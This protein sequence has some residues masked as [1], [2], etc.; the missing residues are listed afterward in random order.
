MTYPALSA[1]R[2]KWGRHMLV[3]ALFAGILVGSYIAFTVW[4]R[5]GSLDS[6]QQDHAEWAYSQ[7]EIE[8]LKLDRA[9]EQARSG[10]SAELE[11]LRKRF[12]IFYSRI[13]IVD[14]LQEAGDFIPEVSKLRSVVDTQIPL[15]D[16]DDTT[17]FNG[18]DGLQRAL[19][20]IKGSPREIALA[21]IAI[22]A[23]SAQ[24]ERHQIVHLMENLFVI[25]LL[26][27]AAL[28]GA[29]IRLS[30][31][32]ITLNRAT[33]EAE[34]NHLRLETTLR[35]S[36][37]AVVVID[38]RGA[39]RDFN[40]SAETIFAIPRDAALGQDFITLLLP[41]HLREKY[42]GML[43]K[44]RSTGI[45]QVADAG[46]QELEMVDHNGRIF[47]VELS[48]SLA[49]SEEGPIFVTYIRDITDK[50]QKEQ[51]I[52]QARDAALAAYGEKSRFFAMM[53]H[54]MRTPLNGVLSAI[55]LL[56]DGRLDAEQQQYLGAALTSGD[57]L[58]SHINDVLAIERSE[59][60]MD[61]QQ[62][63]PC[64]VAS[65]TSGL[66][67]TME[68]L[69][70]SA[71][72]RLQLDQGGLHDRPILTDPR[73]IQQ[74]LV[75]LLSNAIKFSPDGEVTLRTYYQQSKGKTA[76]LHLEVID[77]GPGIFEEDID[78]IFED[79]VSLDSRYE[80]RTGGTGLGLGIVRRVVQ[81]LSGEIR[82]ESVPGEGARFTV[83]LPV[84]LATPSNMP[85]RTSTRTAY[86]N[87]TP[88]RLLVVDDNEINRDL[89]K[90]M[91][92]RLGH[93]VTLAAGGQEAV[94]LAMETSFDAIL[95]D[96]SMPGMNGIQATQAILAGA[97]PNSSTP[98]IAVTAHALPDEQAEFKA[99]GM[100]G[101]L[102]KPLDSKALGATL[103]GFAPRLHAA[104]QPSADVLAIDDTYRQSILN[105]AQV[106]ELLDLLGRDKI[107]E[108]IATLSLRV[109]QDLPALVAAQTAQD[110]QSRSHE[111]AGMCGMFGAHRLHVLLKD[112]ETAC[113]EDDVKTAHD[114][115]KRVPA[116][117]H[118]THAALS[119]R[120]L[121]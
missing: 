27:T 19:D 112:I 28:I 92:R 80:R 40:G 69:A 66:I 75:N 21:S 63:Q 117:W 105:E 86:P 55:H 23:N 79:F 17:L 85:A 37:D 53:S 82:C 25:V 93:D 34:E 110:L 3:L 45:T 22:S 13:D 56:D 72:V 96:I 90:A 60:G 111:L 114:L 97:G 62:L 100:S 88:L 18:L 59:A 51:E 120:V 41:E 81:S 7:L 16:S 76:V 11:N 95:M 50:R 67:D 103:A 87:Q 1:R 32:A 39:I 8:F 47:P 14:R 26:V 2:T 35:A 89:L 108:R 4:N 58:L 98:V 57:I 9:L 73:A 113:K 118:S 99:V 33:R 61:S 115:A 106:A 109:E 46:R 104:T 36:L 48:V 43:A 6:S 119:R 74:I 116:A 49:R 91:L 29:T 77:D 15:I 101:F 68:P 42:N 44:F 24:S 20:D 83:S 31:Q 94:D 5:I 12:D 38:D 78:R 121:Q 70:K 102:Q 10:N 30:R 64:D 52:V 65:L 107:A 71:S 54:E 84:T